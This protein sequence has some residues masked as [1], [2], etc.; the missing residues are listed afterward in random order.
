V[1]PNRLRDQASPN[2]TR[3]GDN[4][5]E[6]PNESGPTT[7][8]IDT[9]GED[10]KRKVRR[11]AGGFA[12]G[13]LGPL[14]VT[15]PLLLPI[16]LFLGGVPTSPLYVVIV[17][18]ALVVVLVGMAALGA[19]TRERAQ[20][21]FGLAGLLLAITIWLLPAIGNGPDPSSVAAVLVGV[22]MFPGLA[23]VGWLAW[24]VIKTRL[25]GDHAVS[26]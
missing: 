12:I 26:S 2:V 21:R 20:G 7:E 1:E 25:P 10:P 6:P 17:G 15:L 9:P 5:A 16:T 3:A 23:A 13:C 19:F 14:I 11:F 4:D 18:G 22:L 8:Q 24:P